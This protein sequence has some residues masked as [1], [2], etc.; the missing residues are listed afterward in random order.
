VAKE[1][2]SY[3]N[4]LIGRFGKATSIDRLLKACSAS[5]T[6]LAVAQ[7]PVAALGYLPVSGR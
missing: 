7:Q 3:I 1:R 6:R 4:V 5:P 2:A